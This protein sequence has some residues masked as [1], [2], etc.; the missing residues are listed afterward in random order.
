MMGRVGKGVAV[1]MGLWIMGAVAGFGEAT[2]A[3]L[4]PPVV[5]RS[6]PTLKK[7][8]ALTFDDGPTKKWTPEILHVLQ[9]NQVKA[10]FFVV[11]R[12]ALRYPQYLH[13]E[14]KAGM[15]VGSHGANH[16]T[17]KGKPAALI[18]REVNENKEILESLGVPKPHLYRL[19]GGNSDKLALSVLTKLHYTVVGWSIDPHDWRHRYSA[20]QLT[21]MVMKHIEPGAIVIF[22]DGPNSSEATVKA[23]AQ[24]IEQL[25][26]EGYRPLT[27]SRLIQSAELP[28]NRLPLD[29]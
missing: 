2:A 24:I 19:P 3:K 25:K 23:V 1:V 20:D 16:M 15:E 11:G 13:E 26:H 18:E 8:V 5:V 27:V 7:V 28:H 29:R 12:Q 6:V 21:T 22:H 17:L 9:R 10:T 14:I 4:A